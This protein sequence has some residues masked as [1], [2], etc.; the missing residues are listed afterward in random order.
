MVRVALLSVVLVATPVMADSI[1]DPVSKFRGGDALLIGNKP[2]RLCGKVERSHGSGE[3]E[4]CPY[5]DKMV[6]LWF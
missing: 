1:T 4:F 3:Q 2:I 5:S 6:Q